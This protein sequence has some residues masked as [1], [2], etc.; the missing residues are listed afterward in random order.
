ME[1]TKTPTTNKET[2]T[3]N[4]RKGIIAQ[5]EQERIE[6]EIIDGERRYYGSI[7]HDEISNDTEFFDEEV[8]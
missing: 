6:Q 7:M 3:M 1:T 8:A 4:P 5:Q 2:K